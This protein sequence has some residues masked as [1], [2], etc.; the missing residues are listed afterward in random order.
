MY[1]SESLGHIWNTRANTTYNTKT[2]IASVSQSSAKI[3]A[4][5]D[6]P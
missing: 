1:F 3:L 2:D 5:P 6:N 4:I